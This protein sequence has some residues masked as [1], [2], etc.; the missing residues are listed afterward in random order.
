MKECK[1]L[2]KEDLLRLIVECVSGPVVYADDISH[3]LSVYGD[4]YVQTEDSD[5]W[6]LRSEISNQNLSLKEAISF[7]EEGCFVASQM[8]SPDQ[9][10]H[11]WGGKFYYEDGA[12]VPLEFFDDQDWA[13]NIPWRIV[14]FKDEVCAHLLNQ[15]HQNSNGYMLENSSYMDAIK[16]RK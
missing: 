3:I 14:A 13:H 1:G 10:M 11:Y 5:C 6:R 15:M 9:S 12:V 7:A 16:K 2:P 4:M 8:F